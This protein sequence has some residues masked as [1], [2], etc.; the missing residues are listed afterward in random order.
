M[1]LAREVGASQLVIATDVEYAYVGFGTA[2]RRALRRVGVGELR[3]YLDRGEFGS[4][5]MAPKAEAACRFVEGGGAR[6]VIASL[7]RIG[8]AVAGVSGTVVEKESE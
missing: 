1:V 3:G 6:A 5:S 8:E 7:D 2:G 4:G